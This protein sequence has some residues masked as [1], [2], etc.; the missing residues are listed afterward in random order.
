MIRKLRK[1]DIN[2][3]MEIW[4][5]STIKAHKFIPEDYWL[6]NYFVVKETYIPLSKTFIYEE[7]GNNKGFI[8][9][10][11]DKFIGALFVDVNY[12]GQGIG[13]KLIEFAKQN[14]KEL[15]LAVYKN[16]EK[17]VDFYKKVGFIIEKEQI[18]EDSKEKEF[19]M[20]WSI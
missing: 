1:E 18:N 8:S 2:D 10:I 15:S 20:S 19:I 12:Q 5:K 4:E 6:K 3:I 14:Y 13:T 11:D 9:I 16:N 17:S 7:N